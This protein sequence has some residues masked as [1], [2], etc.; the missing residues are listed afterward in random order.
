LVVP[1]YPQLRKLPK[2]KSR[3][4]AA[5]LLRLKQ[6]FAAEGLPEK[7]VDGNLLLA[8]WNI[9]EFGGNKFGGRDEEA[10]YYIAEIISRFDLIAIQE[11]RDD[12]TDLEKT[13]R[14]IGSW[15]KVLYTDVTAGKRGNQE[16]TGF[17][18]DSRKIIFGGLAGEIVM[19]PIESGTGAGAAE[20]IA[21]TPMI[22]GFRAGWFKFTI[23]TA[24]LFYGDEKPD[25]PRRLREMRDLAK[26]LRTAAASNTAWAKNMIVLGDFNI[27]Q[28][29]DET[30]KALVDNGFTVPPG[31]LKLTSNLAGGKHYDQIAFIAPTVMDQLA[32]AAAGV[33]NFQKYVYRDGDE[34]DYKADLG[35]SKYKT[36]RTYKLS[37]HLPLWVELK[38]DFGESYLTKLAT[39]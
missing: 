30:F 14:T 7:R 12:I 16:R 20:Q 10:L 19:P 28:T 21:R 36:W 15:W 3:R 1:F 11:L 25:D 4:A 13:L 9:R 18:Y 39:P 24:H 35:T 31:I 33:F 38:T 27:F 8:T 2:E 23:C 26:F 5:G 29:T 17:L 34:A 32:G 22:V 37:D 6:S